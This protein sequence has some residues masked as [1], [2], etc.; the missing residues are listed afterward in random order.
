MLVCSLCFLGGCGEEEIEV[1]EA[2]QP[3][4]ASNTA[5]DPNDGGDH[6]GHDH[7]D[8]DHAA[9]ASP[10]DNSASTV[11]GKF[12]VKLP[13]GWKQTQPGSMIL[14]SY[15]TVSG[16]AV[17]VSAFPG[18]VGG[19]AANVA[20]WRRQLGLNP[21]SPDQLQ[22]ALKADKIGPIDASRVDFANDTQRLVVSFGMVDGKTWFIK[23]T[24]TSEQ[25]Q[26]ALPRFDQFLKTVNWQ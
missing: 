2:P 19:V 4:I 14:H 16:A 17:N 5:H 10:T 11:S 22:P 12:T 15:Q 21:L 20:R 26:T 24:G 1:Y 6:A 18:D 13:E 3:A 9:H 7:A 25:V 8:H 23:L